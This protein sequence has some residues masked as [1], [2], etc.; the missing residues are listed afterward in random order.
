MRTLRIDSCDECPFEY[1]ATCQHPDRQSRS[2][3]IGSPRP[4]EW[5]PLKREGVTVILTYRTG[6]IP[7]KE[8]P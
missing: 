4:P 5:C 3:F 1:D 8:S 6:E 7:F 2:S